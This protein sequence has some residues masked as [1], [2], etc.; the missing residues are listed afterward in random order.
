MRPYLIS[1]E[2]LARQVFRYHPA[3]RF[4]AFLVCAFL[5][6]QIPFIVW[7]VNERHLTGQGQERA[8]QLASD[9]QR[10][11]TDRKALAPTEKKL[12]RIQDLAPLLRARLPI[13]AVLG[14]IEQLTP[15][16][17][18][19]ARITIN[20]EGFQPLQIESG[21]FHVPQQIR[22]EIEGEQPL[23][24]GDPEAYDH[25]AQALLRSLPPESKIAESNLEGGLDAEPYR[26]FRLT[27]I[28][29]TNANYFGLGVTKLAT[30]NTL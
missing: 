14:K 24:A 29:P 3:Y 20:A 25:L 18:T 27:L 7:I 9:A 12:K 13:G 26:T 6:A 16:D 15:P 21:L 2:V 1:P 30:Q 8:S 28:A 22:I 23:R 5:V 11:A 4:A 17:L 19:V 10:I